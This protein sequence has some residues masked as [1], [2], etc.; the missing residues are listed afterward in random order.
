MR[1]SAGGTSPGSAGGSSFRMAAMVSADVGRAN[2]AR[3]SEHLV[4]NRPE[5]EEIGTL[6]ESFAAN[7]LGRHVAC[8]AHHGSSVGLRVETVAAVDI[9]TRPRQL[10]DAEVKDL[11]S[12]VAGDKHILGL[13]VAV[14]DV[15]VVRGGE[16]FCDL[17]RVIDGFA[18]R[19]RSST[20]AAA[21]RFSV[22]QFRDDVRGV[23]MAADIVDREHIRVI[24]LAGPA[25]FLFESAHPVRIHCH[26]TRRSA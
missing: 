14:N 16:P 8:G 26:A 25:R 7:L 19:Q 12:P 5:A 9:I 4:E 1:P 10:R 17:T 22:E 2:A 23:G 15:L 18:H 24:K 13:H 20:K 6:V 3:R 21:K 11:D